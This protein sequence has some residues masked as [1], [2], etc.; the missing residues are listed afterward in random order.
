MADAREAFRE[1]QRR[2]PTASR[3]PDSVYRI[4][5]IQIEMDDLDEAE[6]TLRRSVNTYAGSIMAELAADKLDEIR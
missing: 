4:A 3:V 2:C 5:V 6:Q 1:V